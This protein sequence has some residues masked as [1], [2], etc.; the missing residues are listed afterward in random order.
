MPDNLDYIVKIGRSRT[1]KKKYDAEIHTPNG[2]ILLATVDNEGEPQEYN[3]KADCVGAMEAF[4]A[5]A[6]AGRVQFEIGG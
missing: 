2:R 4:V 5:H 3:N 6:K 1:N